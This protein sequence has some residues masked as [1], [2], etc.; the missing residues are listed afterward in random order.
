MDDLHWHTS[1]IASHQSL[2]SKQN[3]YLAP[4]IHLHGEA[5]VVISMILGAFITALVILAACLGSNC[6]PQTATNFNRRRNHPPRSFE[7]LNELLCELDGNETGVLLEEGFNEIS[8]E[9]FFPDI[10][11][12]K[13][14]RPEL[15][16][17]D[18]EDGGLDEPLI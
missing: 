14:T 12:G 2:S 7:S 8:V 10:L 11:S 13:R 4:M 3:L 18:Y 17:Q 1:T 16:L 15:R 5:L 9:S 6:C